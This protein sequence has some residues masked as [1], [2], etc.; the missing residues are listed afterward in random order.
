MN[1]LSSCHP[2]VSLFYFLS[3]FVLTM[4]I[5]NPL[6]LITAL[7]G[8]ILFFI[9]VQKDIRISREFGFSFVLFIII[10]LTNP[11]FSHNGVTALFFLNGNPV[12]LEAILYGVNIAVMLT[13]VIYWFKC[14]SIV[15]TS[16]KIIYLFGKLSPKISLLISTAFRFIPLFKIQSQK[17]RQSQKSMGLYATDSWIDKLKGTARV[18]S[19]LI[20][21]AFENAID[22]GSSMKARGYGLKGRSHYSLFR[23][24]K[25]DAVIFLL[26]AILDSI[27]IF[28]MSMGYLDFVFYPEITITAI[29]AYNVTACL[30][31]ALL[32]FL[33]FILEVR[34]GLLWKYY[35]SKI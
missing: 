33:P 31:F 1:S 20:T 6:L 11:L 12:T 10:S 14:F 25:S 30:M 15:I 3:V 21:W 29:N 35:R 28:V 8:S 23:F 7:S 16:D 18:Y 2:I 9:S 22:T 26:I 17:I 4:F 24:R 34:E 32:S 13:A 27:V 19:S 5:S